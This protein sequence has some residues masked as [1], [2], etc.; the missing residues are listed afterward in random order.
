MKKMIS[1]ADEYDGVRFELKLWGEVNDNDFEGDFIQK[2]FNP[3][4][5]LYLILDTKRIPE[6]YNPE[7]FLLKP[8]KNDRFPRH[9]F[10]N[11]M[12]HPILN[13]ID[14][15]GGITYYEKLGNGMIKVGCDYNHSGDH[16]NMFSF[17]HLKRDAIE[18]IKSFKTMIP[19]YKYWCNGNGKIYDKSE[20]II[21]DNCFYSKEYW[22]EKHPEWFVEAT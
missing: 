22:F 15:H 12:S 2:E 19:D 17:K 10:Y 20:G 4:W 21:K 18:A 1:Y 11:Y 6:K 7:S 9:T 3:I 8:K 16:A 5:N 13:S 14:F